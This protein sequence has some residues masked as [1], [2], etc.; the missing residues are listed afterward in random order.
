MKGAEG[1]ETKMN[2]SCRLDSFLHIKVMNIHKL[3]SS[4]LGLQSCTA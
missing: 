4:S 3:T 2:L 1:E